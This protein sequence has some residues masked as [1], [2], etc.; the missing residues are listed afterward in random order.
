MGKRLVL[1]GGGHAHM[2][3]LANLHNFVE[4][5]HE[6]IVVGPSEYHYYSGMGPGMLGGVYQPEEI[7][8]A[9]RH[10]VE[11][12]GGT[13]V[14]D[15]AI[16]V[17][18]QEK[19]LHLQSGQTL[20]YDVISFNAGSY[21]PKPAIAME[22]EN[23]YSVKPIEKLM[24]AKTR[25]QELFSR[26]VALVSIV[27]GG[28]SSAEVAGNVWRL[29]RDQGTHQP[30]IRIFAG[31]KFMGRFPEAVRSRVKNSLVKRGIEIIT[32][33]YVEELSQAAIRLK[34]GNRYNTDFTFL[35]L[36]VRPSNIFV[37]SSG[38]R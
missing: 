33:S 14:R 25:L 34:S 6:V 7:R 13:F 19:I 29:A 16:R 30:K 28:P 11:K 31:Q 18:A 23:I 3:T 20:P 37:D 17:E 22:G 5:G 8:F 12:L 2:M 10:L 35:A 15:R 21:V 38:H 27:G 1:V 4:K 24:E 9:T 32:E 36:G 26:K